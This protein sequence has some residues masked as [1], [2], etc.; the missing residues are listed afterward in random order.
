MATDLSGFT[1]TRKILIGGD[2]FSSLVD[3]CS[4]SW[5]E[6]GGPQQASLRISS[7]DFDESYGIQQGDDVDIRYGDAIGTRMWRGIV[8]EISTSLTDGLSITAA[9]PKLRL[10]ES[11]PTGIFGTLA[12]T[13]PPL[14][15][16]ATTSNAATGVDGIQTDLSL[17][18]LARSIDADGTTDYTDTTA[19]PASPLGYNASFPFRLGIPAGT[20]AANKQLDLSWTCGQNAT[21][22]EI[23]LIFD[24]FG[25][26]QRLEFYDAVGD[27][28]S[29][30]GVF[31][32]TE[33][34]TFADSN[35]A[36][37]ATIAG[38]TIEDIV[39]HLL[40]TYLPTGMTKGT[41]D[42]D[43]LN[44]NVDLFDL[45]NSGSD[46][47]QVLT[48][49]RDL[50]GDVQ[51]YVDASLAVH[52][53]VIGTASAATFQI[54]GTPGTL[55]AADHDVLIG[56]VKKQTREG[57]TIVKIEGEDA[58]E[59]SDLEDNDADWESTTTPTSPDE[60]FASITGDGRVHSIG[61]SASSPPTIPIGATKANFIDVDYPTLQ[62]WL[63]DFPNQRFIYLKKDDLPTAF[64]TDVLD[65]MRT[66]VTTPPDAFSP[67]AA[68]PG[69]VGNRPRMMTLAAP[70]ISTILSAGILA[71]NFLLK[72]NPNPVQW[73]CSLEKVQTLYV[74]GQDRITV[75]NTRGIT[76][77]LPIVAITY[78]MDETISASVTVGDTVI[79]AL[80]EHMMQTRSLAR[81]SLQK[82]HPTRWQT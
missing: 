23:E 56:L 62:S 31:S 20:I 68:S 82:N 50:S 71:N 11:M 59:D 49:L 58:M 8:V 7:A 35:T 60:S 54:Q 39:N 46:L 77:D 22:T 79:S 41:V 34:T 66:K 28:L 9:G 42:I 29:I 47:N 37:Q 17:F 75:I 80:D 78:Q 25:P 24:L 52:F 45:T 26:D 44:V 64:I 76:Y 21:G 53:V 10:W 72:R 16:S 19:N 13:G 43:A 4:F 65:K 6:C 30:D 63:D 70:G 12:D 40:D 69:A 81:M 18:I 5:G 33:G 48:A 2:D 32:P 67:D 27:T 38:T 61:V 74:P 15:L 1:Y 57:I 51:W 14:L 36:R 55:S 3:Q 73:S